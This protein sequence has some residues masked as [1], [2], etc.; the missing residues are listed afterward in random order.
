MHISQ[1]EMLASA[2]A[3]DTWGKHLSRRRVV[4]RCDNL[5]SVMT[6]NQ[7]SGALGSGSTSDAGMLVVAREI[8]FI[9]AKHSFTTRSKHIGTKLN[10]LADAASRAE[11][12]RF[13]AFGDNGKLVSWTLGKTGWT[14]QVF[15]ILFL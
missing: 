8:F 14:S 1:L 10:V 5:S 12:D 15:E 4:T 11:W 3:F 13:F 7:L 2:M 9:C 6:I